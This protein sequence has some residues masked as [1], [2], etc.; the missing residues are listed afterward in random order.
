MSLSPKEEVNIAVHTSLERSAEAKAIVSKVSSSR[1]RMAKVTLAM[2]D[3]EALLVNGR[4]KMA[5]AD[6]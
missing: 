1:Q 5:G 6:F 2:R 4:L 3:A